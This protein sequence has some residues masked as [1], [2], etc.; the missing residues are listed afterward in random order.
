MNWL[1]GLTGVP[2][3]RVILSYTGNSEQAWDTYDCLKTK[4][5]N[6]LEDPR[7]GTR[8]ILVCLLVFRASLV[9]Q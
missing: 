5:Q 2:A 6:T 9:K 4:A 1:W 3:L 8:V 7:A